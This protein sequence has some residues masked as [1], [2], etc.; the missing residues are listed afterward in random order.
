MPS[1]AYEYECDMSSGFVL[2]P[3]DHNR[4]GFITAL[5]GFGMSAPLATDLLVTVPFSGGAQ[6][7]FSGLQYQSGSVMGSAKVAGVIEKFSWRGG[8]GDAIEIDFYV[9]QTNAMQIKALMQLALKMSSMKP[10]AWWI[11]NYDQ[12]TK[13]WYEQAYPQGGSVSG[14]I[15]G[16]ANPELNVDLDPVPAQAGIDVMVYKISLAV[17]PAANLSYALMFANT[18]AQ[19]LTKQWGLVV[20][21]LAKG[22]I[23]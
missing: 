2:N 20:G 22:A 3:N 18:P 13:Q 10:L 5:G 23:T 14:L 7:T 12:E 11:A 1:I 6:P 19:R 21:A 9:S 4:I 16:K 17:V 8:A 15:Q